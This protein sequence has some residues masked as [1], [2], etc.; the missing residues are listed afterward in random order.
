M[1]FAVIYTCYSKI[2]DDFFTYSK[3]KIYH[4]CTIY[5][6]GSSNRLSVL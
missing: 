3:D 2:Q 1:L 6:I 4:K 5:I